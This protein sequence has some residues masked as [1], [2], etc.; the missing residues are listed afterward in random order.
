[1][2][3]TR[4]AIH[5]PGIAHGPGRPAGSQIGNIVVSATLVGR[6]AE[7]EMSSDPTEQMHELF[8]TMVRFL[9]AAGASVDDVIRVNITVAESEYRELMNLEWATYFN[10]QESLPTRETTVAPLP[11][12]LVAVL[13]LM[14][15]TG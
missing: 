6:T 5:I 13:D 9:E 11:G 3:P 10:D 7:G 12:G 1:M 2:S 8:L 14:A 15:V 4:R